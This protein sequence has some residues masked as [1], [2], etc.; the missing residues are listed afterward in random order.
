[1]TEEESTPQDQLTQEEMAELQKFVSSSAPTP[2]ENHNA[3]KFIHSVSTSKDTTKTGYLQSEEVGTPL[4]PTRTYKELEVFCNDIGDMP[5]FADWFRQGSEIVTSTSLS[6][7]AKLLELAVI[8]KRQLEDV[9]KQAPKENKG[10]FKKKK[11][12]E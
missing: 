1:M 4:L 10:W 2:D 12:P 6:K 7:D 3:H 5:Y 11:P 8:V 9:T